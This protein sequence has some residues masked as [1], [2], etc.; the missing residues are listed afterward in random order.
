M[1]FYTL[2]LYI[3]LQD[4]LN[5]QTLFTHFTNYTETVHEQSKYLFKQIVLVKFFLS[6]VPVNFMLSW[7]LISWTWLHYLNQIKYCKLI[8]HSFDLHVCSYPVIAH[9]DWKKNK[10][11]LVMHN[12]IMILLVSIC[13]GSIS[14]NQ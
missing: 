4:S 2:H 13:S 9:L 8:G 1:H 12:L 7:Q 11:K 6:D 3:L 14:F 10:T 5:V